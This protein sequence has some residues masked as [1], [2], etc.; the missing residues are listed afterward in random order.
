MSGLDFALL[1]LV[2]TGVFFALRSMRRG[3][4]CCGDCKRCRGCRKSG[5]KNGTSIRHSP[6]ETANIRSSK[7]R[8]LF[9]PS[10]S[11]A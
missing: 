9:Y 1:A 11:L 5:E 3:S 4:G 7:Y 8:V 6:S 10:R 2:G